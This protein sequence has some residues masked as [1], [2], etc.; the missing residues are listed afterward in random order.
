MASNDVSTSKWEKISSDQESLNILNNLSDPFES[1]QGFE[2]YKI[3]QVNIKFN[4]KIFRITLRDYSSDVGIL[5]EIFLQEIYVVPMNYNFAEG[6]IMD[7]GGN[8]GLSSLY[9]HAMFP[10]ANIY[11]FEPFE[12]NFRI[13]EKNVC[14]P[15]SKIRPYKLAVSDNSNDKFCEFSDNNFNFGGIGIKPYGSVIVKCVTLSAFCN[16]HDINRINIMKIDCEGS[17]Y[18]I[19]YGLDKSMFDRIDII[20]GEFHGAESA[21]ELLA[22]LSQ[23]YNIGIRKVYHNPVLHFVAVN[24]LIPYHPPVH[25]QIGSIVNIEGDYFIN[26]N[27]NEGPGCALYGPYKKYFPGDYTVKF[28]IRLTENSS[29]SGSSGEFSSIDVCS[30]CTNIL[31][32]KV[33]TISDTVN[34]SA[35]QLNFCVK[36]PSILEFRVMSKGNVDFLVKAYPMVTIRK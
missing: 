33:L 30:D 28:D 1:V 10:E 19:L 29:L 23:F 17:E 3:R 34:D 31:S 25:H 2:G 8:I 7:I 4:N 22:Y 12:D 16:T 11:T 26:V 18:G 5:E 15:G 20:V 14:F 32:E 9:L 24:K 35:M 13:L 6:V 21:I 36:E 27:K